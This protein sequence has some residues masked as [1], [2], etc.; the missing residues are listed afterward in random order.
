[1]APDWEK[2][3]NDW[4][5]DKVGLIAE[6]DC[7]AEGKPLCDANG[8]R[9]FPTLKYGDPT[10]LD[11]YQGGRD[12]DSL[13]S[14]AKKNLIPVCSVNNIDLCDDEKK[15]LIGKYQGM[16]AEELDAAIEGEETKLADAEELFK[17]EVQKLQ[18]AYQKLS[19]DK[20]NTIAEVK[21]SGL[22]M[23]KSVKAAMTKS[24]SSDEL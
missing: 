20:D 18:E 4:S 15:A 7:T 16:S 21:G 9:G 2:L 13:A 14:F 6:I 22:G 10:S 8:I 19:T 1:M 3:A 24:S 23:M 17:N 12:F 5:D 11:D